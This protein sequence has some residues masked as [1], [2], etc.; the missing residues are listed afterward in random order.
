MP[1]VDLNR[2]LSDQ[3]YDALTAM[4]SRVVDGKI[5]NLEALDGFLT[6]LV[7]CPEPILP[8]EFVPVILSGQTEDDDLVFESTEE[9]EE[10]YGILVRYWNQ[11][12][13]TFREGDVY[14]PFLFV[15]EKGVAHGN[16]WAQG[17][18]KGTHVH[19]DAWLE[20]LNDEDR[21]GPFVPIWALAYEHAEDPSLR[22]YKEPMSVERRE[23]LLVAMIA[24]VKNLYDIFRKE[25]ANK[26][27]KHMGPLTSYSK[28]GRND[29]CPCG[30]G[31]KFKKCCGQMTFH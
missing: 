23:Q 28:V 22:P 29:P 17:F 18:L 20:I 24:G 21:S 25:G 8:S 12:N 15:D 7:I 11:I 2:E 6:A 9:A 19:C 5:P 31:K 13:R 30:S 16:D 4:L 3:D 1:N 26:K 14:M 27:A 10:F